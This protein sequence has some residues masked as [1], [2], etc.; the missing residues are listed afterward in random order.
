MRHYVLIDSSVVIY[1]IEKLMEPYRD[2]PQER[3]D[4]ILMAR[5][6][7]INSCDWLNI[8]K[9]GDFYPIWLFD[10]PIRG[11]YWRH[12]YLKNTGIKYKHSRKS[13][14][15]YWW[16]IKSYLLKTINNYGWKSLGVRGYEA[17]DIAS[18]MVRVINNSDHITL[19][20]IDTDWLGM[21][22][23]NTDWFSLFD[24]SWLPRVKEFIRYRGNISDINKWAKKALKIKSDFLVPSD[25][26]SHKSKK[27]DRSDNLPPNSPIEVINLF[28]PPPKFDLLSKGLKLDNIMDSSAC[29]GG[30]SKAS[31]YLL[32]VGAK[33]YP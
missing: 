15:D 31:D 25:I 2:L 8:Y 29:Y 19:G 28:N 6:F 11:K 26:W 18:L 16:H 7:Y 3:M 21:V 20:T 14:T 22:S 12:S 17:D 1:D 5:L 10:C 23:D 30:G 27:G 33:L 4:N 24:Y 9:K 32:S 13:K